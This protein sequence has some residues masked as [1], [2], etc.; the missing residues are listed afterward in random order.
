MHTSRLKSALYYAD[1]YGWKVVPLHVNPNLG[2]Q[3]SD[4]AVVQE[5][6]HLPHIDYRTD[7][8]SNTEQIQEW[9]DQLSHSP[10]AVLTGSES[11]IVVVELPASVNGTEAQESFRRLCGGQPMTKRFTAHDRIFY[12]F[13]YPDVAGPLPPLTRT[14]G[15]VFKGDRALVKLPRIQEQKW[16]ILETDDVAPLP[17]SLFDTF[18]RAFPEEVQRNVAKPA[19]DAKESSRDPSPSIPASK[20]ATDIR[21]M[22]ARTMDCRTADN[23]AEDS[24][25]RAS[26]SATD[27]RTTAHPQ[28]NGAAGSM[29]SGPAASVGFQTGDDL[30]PQA[31]DWDRLCG[32]P[33]LLRDGLSVLTGPPKAAGKS[34][35]VVNLMASIA[36]GTHFLGF[37][38][39]AA[40]VVALVDLPPAS[41]RRLLY[42]IG[43]TDEAALGRLH[44]LHPKAVHRF[45]WKR[46]VTQL[47][48]QAAAVGAPVIIVDSLDQLLELKTGLSACTDADAVHMLTAEAPPDTAV[49]AV[50]ALPDVSPFEPFR[51]TVSK[52]ALLGEASDLVIRMDALHAPDRPTLRRLTAVGRSGMIPTQF[53]VEMARG[54]Y[55]R[56]RAASLPDVTPHADR[57]PRSLDP[58]GADMV[59]VGPSDPDAQP[60][61]VSS[62]PAYRSLAQDTGS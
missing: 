3:Q 33:W 23:G 59:S 20:R 27:G 40:H 22:D 58:G 49:L 39:T 42:R 16:N 32:V 29:P 24:P 21:K 31:G 45:G 62:T 53:Y 51:K 55:G 44:V 36:A 37:P 2:A 4:D 9:W 25:G 43:L 14:S 6:G 8:S 19:V 38:T 60:A 26:R 52:L 10:V 41:F 48:D 17:P 34:T 61:T 46:V 13:Q 15:M 5:I 30:R 1:T 12:F 28:K 35:A 57:R 47:Y 7:A 50:Q 54:V 18:W 56:V 11:G